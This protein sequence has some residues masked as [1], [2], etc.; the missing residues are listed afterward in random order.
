MVTRP[1]TAADGAPAARA[2]IV[3]PTTPNMRRAA[4]PDCTLPGM[5]KGYRPLRSASTHG[6]HA[7]APA[8]LLALTLGICAPLASQQP[9]IEASVH[10]LVL[11]NAFHTTDNVNNSDVPQFAV[12][13][14]PAPEA[15]TSSAT[16]RQSRVTV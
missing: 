8:A 10:G 1:L 9:D 2:T 11:M 4:R 13:A 15:S 16:V 7:R 14:G 12:P 6:T 5:P 3:S